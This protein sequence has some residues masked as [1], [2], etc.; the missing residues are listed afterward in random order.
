MMAPRKNKATEMACYGHSDLNV[1]A[2]IVA[3]LEGGTLYDAAS[4]RAAQKIVSV[5]HKEQSRL[6]RLHDQGV[7]LINEQSEA[8]METRK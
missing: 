1:F 6:L 7:R 2:S 3:I 5:C 8:M 4:K